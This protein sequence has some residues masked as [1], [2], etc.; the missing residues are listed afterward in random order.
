MKKFFSPPIEYLLEELRR[1]P[2]GIPGALV[3]MEVF[4]GVQ[5]IAVIDALIVFPRVE[6]VPKVI[7]QLLI[8]RVSAVLM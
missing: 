5:T 2:V 7:A 4:Q 6:S 3:I 1:L 8:V